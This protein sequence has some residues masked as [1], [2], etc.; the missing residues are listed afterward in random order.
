MQPLCLI[1]DADDSADRKPCTKYCDTLGLYS[2]PNYSRTE[3]INASGIGTVALQVEEETG[4]PILVIETSY[5]TGQRILEFDEGK[6]SKDVRA[7]CKEASDYLIA[8]GNHFLP[9]RTVSRR[10]RGK[11]DQ[12]LSGTI[13]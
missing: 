12:D 5:P 9:K 7:G 4:L 3:L 13:T 6:Q 1:L 10:I 8:T 2:Y 11:E